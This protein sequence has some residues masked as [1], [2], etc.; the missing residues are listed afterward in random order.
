MLYRD[1]CVEPSPNL[2]VE[3]H[4]H[5][6]RVTHGHQVLQDAIGGVLLHYAHVPIE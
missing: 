4:L 3:G 5:P 2:V 6:S 1:S